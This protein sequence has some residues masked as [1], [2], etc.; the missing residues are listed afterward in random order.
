V[1]RTVLAAVAALLL[2]SCSPAGEPGADR[3]DPSPTATAGPE[4]PSS[5]EHRATLVFA[6]KGDWGAG[7]PQQRSMTRRMCAQRSR[8][9]F[10]I[11]VTTGDNF[12]A[13]DGTATRSNYYEPERCLIEYPGHRWRASWGNHDAYGTSTFRVLGAR[14]FYSWTEG[15]IDFFALDS[16]R[17]DDTQQRAWLERGLAES[18]AKIKIAHFHH[19]PF[20]VGAHKDNEKVKKN[21]VP[22][23]ERF[24][25]TLVLAGHNHG[26]EHHRRNGI[27]YV[28]TGGGGAKTYPC[29]GIRQGLE[30]C[31]P[32]HHFLLVTAGERSVDVRAIRIDGTTLDRFSIAVPT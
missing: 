14:R 5:P 1:R 29:L 9:Q 22:L 19:P 23:F 11:V 8:T 10:E 32:E 4:T 18:T 31:R 26:Y 7:T 24:N 2:A 13:P 15:G 6:V 30:L 16:N 17:A 27:H 28:I 25:V 20:T 3:R 12:Y 21:W